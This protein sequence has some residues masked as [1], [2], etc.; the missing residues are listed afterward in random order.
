[1]SNDKVEEAI[2]AGIP[3]TVTVVGVEG[4]P[5]A[6]LHR[7]ACSRLGGLRGSKRRIGTAWISLGGGYGSGFESTFGEWVT[8]KEG[9]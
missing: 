7:T 6:S 9:E 1:M 2:S 4:G 5:M 8:V 3:A